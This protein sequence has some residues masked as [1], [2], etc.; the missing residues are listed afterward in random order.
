KDGGSISVATSGG[1]GATFN[2]LGTLSAAQFIY[3]LVQGNK[4]TV[5]TPGSVIPFPDTNIGE[6]S[7]AVI[8]VMN[9]GNVIGTVGALVL[10]GADFSITGAP[11]IPAIIQPNSSF[12]F[13]LIFTPTQAVQR[14]A[15]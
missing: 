10:N 13:T 7:S 2:L 6:T 4:T 5:I 14:Q 9:T 3:S 8:Q 1:G 11:I 12:T 15:S